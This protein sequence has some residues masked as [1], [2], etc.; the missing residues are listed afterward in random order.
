MST[1]LP[2]PVRASKAHAPII[3]VIL[4][5]AVSFTQTTTTQDADALEAQ[6]GTCAK[7][8]IPAEKC[9]PEIYQRLKAKDN[10]PLDPKTASVLQALKVYQS[11]LKNPDSMQLRTAYLTDEGAACLEVGA[12]NG[13]GGVSVSRVVYV[14][15][16]W[17]GVKRLREH[18]L[19]EDGFSGSS[20]RWPGICQK[21][22]A[23][24]GTGGD[25][26]PGTDVTD[27]V[28]QALKR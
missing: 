3:A 15:P 5:S 27:E 14:P 20:D 19:D 28:N 11:R 22:R 25:M 26:K 17:K 4:L 21:P 6:Y 9:M 12:Q 8:H 7:H 24:A 1:S 2:L 16:D 18:W 23:L 10:A 13:T